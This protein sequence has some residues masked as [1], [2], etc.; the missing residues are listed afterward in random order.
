MTCDMMVDFVN[1]NELSAAL[2]AEDRARFSRNNRSCNFT[3]V[4][5]AEQAKQIKDLIAR[6]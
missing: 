6:V 3:Q 1:G 4:I 5:A 2:P